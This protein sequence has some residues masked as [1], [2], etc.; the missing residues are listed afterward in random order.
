MFEDFLKNNAPTPW[1]N[2]IADEKD[3]EVKVNMWNRQYTVGKNCLLSSIISGGEEMLE[4]P[5]TIHAIENGKEVVFGDAHTF[6]MNQSGR[7]V[8]VCSATRSNRFV[9]NTA[10]KI[11]Y[12]G[13]CKIDLKIMPVGLTVM[14]VFGLDKHNAKQFDLDALWVEVPIKESIA[15]DYHYWP[16]MW[17]SLQAKFD[18]EEDKIPY[19]TVCMSRKLKSSLS[20][21]FKPGIYFGNGDKGLGY[22]A[23]SAE[24]WQFAEKEAL[25]IEKKEDGK[26]VFKINLLN[27]QPKKWEYP[28]APHNPVYS[29][30]A[31]SFSFG[32]QATPVK[33][34]PDNPYKEKAVH[35]DCF[36]KILIEYYDF[37]LNTS[38][39]EGYAC[40]LDKIAAEGVTLLYIHEKWNKIQNYWEIAVSDRARIQEIIKQCHLR[41][42]KVIPYFGY[43]LSTLNPNYTQWE[44]EHDSIQVKEGPT[45]NMHGWY[46]QP[47]QRDYVV[48]YGSSFTDKMLAGLEKMFDE[49]AFDGIYLDSTVYPNFCLEHSCGYVDANGVR[50]TTHP[51]LGVRRF[52]EGLY[53]L[54]HPRGKIISAHISNYIAPSAMSFCDYVWDGEAIQIYLKDNGIDVIPQEYMKAEYV[55]RAIGVP[56]EYLV[57]TFPNWSYE[58]GLSLCLI[59]GMLPKP[60][61]IGLPLEITH[62]LWDIYD[63]FPIAN[64]TFI[65][66][67]KNDRITYKSEDIKCSLYEYKDSHG[68]RKW[69]VIIANPTSNTATA[70]MK[71]SATMRVNDERERKL[72]SSACDS[73]DVTLAPCQTLIYLADEIVK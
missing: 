67:W 45:E 1:V 52:M 40:N 46:R 65:P 56:Y 59:Y 9:V 42:I 18:K 66:Y 62:K 31:I 15:Q 23:E 48:C 10:L 68:V 33:K 5:M 38:D 22:F 8:V 20:L 36:K 6:I 29:F 71:M 7:E 13:L 60:N 69:L 58:E 25:R 21:D 2:L 24:N 3:D 72:I 47:N 28:P 34:M 64:S 55:P 73:F 26:V 37:L 32:F 27:S 57:Y 43:E 17:P 4:A 53:N 63:A 12:D 54:L 51:V 19:S 35:I 41:G 50:R 16:S 39:Y 11:E 61:D 70:T 30:M 49:Y 44:K 14:E